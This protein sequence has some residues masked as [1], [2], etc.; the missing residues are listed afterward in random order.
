MKYSNPKAL[1][2]PNLRKYKR[3]AAGFP[4]AF[5]G[6]Q[7]SL[8][9]RGRSGGHARV[10]VVLL[11]PDAAAPAVF[12]GL[13]A[14]LFAGADAAVAGCAGFEAGVTCFAAFRSC[15]FVGRHRA[16]FHALVDALLLVGV[17][18]DVLLHALARLAVGVA[19]LRV[20]LLVIDRGAFL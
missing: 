13:D 4:A 14:L 16:G 15:F 18:L 1:R 12:A 10:G 3:K 8:L 6:G 2:N 9:V 11:A 17:A 7:S 5:R 20:V 19:G